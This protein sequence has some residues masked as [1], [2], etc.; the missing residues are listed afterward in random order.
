MVDASG[1]RVYSEL[2]PFW[3]LISPV[4]DYAEEAAWI[5]DLLGRARI[6]VRELLELGSG[7][8]HCAFHLKAGRA[9][10]LTD[11]SPDMLALSARLNPECTHA[12]GDM[13]TLRLGRTFDAV[14]LYDAIDYMSTQ[15]ALGEAIAT[16]WAHC[17]PGGV[18]VFAPD[19]VCERFE[20]GEEVGG[21]DA[22]DG[23]GVRFLEWTWDPDPDDEQVRT[24]YAFVVR[25]ADGSI[26]HV[27]ETHETGL[28]ATA[29]WVRLLEAEGF[30]VDV[31]EEETAEERT[32]R[33]AFLAHRPIA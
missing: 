28:F 29:D 8:G 3:P 21:S 12:E 30:Y 23:A 25:D 19:H 31:V 24:E 14:L 4:E 20:P 18:A 27:H 9:L 5:E 13:R 1:T 6:D 11:L 16:A 33:I 7:G 17:R 26:R 10:T 15:M 32:P 22:A 2:A